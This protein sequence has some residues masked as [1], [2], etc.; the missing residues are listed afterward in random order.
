[1]AWPAAGPPSSGGRPRRASVSRLRARAVVMSVFDTHRVG[2]FITEGEFNTGMCAVGSYHAA[3]YVTRVKAVKFTGV[4]GNAERSRRGGQK[5]VAAVFC[6]ITFRT[7][8]V[9]LSIVHTKCCSERVNSDGCVALHRGVAS[10]TTQGGDD[11]GPD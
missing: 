9:D 2:V 1:M 3:H 7:R 8:S 11:A 10:V 4:K 5:C 6:E